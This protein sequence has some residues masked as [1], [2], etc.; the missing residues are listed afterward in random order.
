M[1]RL[2]GVTALTASIFAAGCH[3]RPRTWSQG[4]AELEASSGGARTAS[5]GDGDIVEFDLTRGAPESAA[6]GLLGAPSRQTYYR[7]VTLLKQLPSETTSR[8]VLIRLG[9]ARF[10]WSR[11]QELAALFAKVR[12]SKKQIVCHADGY[13]NASTWIIARGCDRIWVSPAGGVETTGIA[14]E[15]VYMN[16]LLTEKL[17]VDVDFLQIG[18]FKGAEEPFTRNGPSPEAK[19]SLEGVLGAI[20]EQWLAGITEARGKALAEAIE[21]GPFGAE[22][23]K[24]RGIVD[25]VG[26]LDEAREEAKKITGGQTFEVRFGSAAHSADRPDLSEVIRAIAGGGNGSRGGPAHV[27]LVRA[28]GAI[29]MDGSGGVLGQRSGITE[30][31]LGRTV[32]ALTDDASVKAVVLRI[33]SPGGSALASDLLWRALM[34]LRAKKPLVVSIGDM[35]ASGGYYLA[36]TANRIIAE[37]TSIVGS[38]GVV[39][40][41]LAFGPA[42]EQIGVHTEAIGAPGSKAAMR[43]SYE[44]L[45]LPWDA[46]TRERVKSE[47]T[48]VYDLFLRRVAEGR[49]IPVETVAGAAEGRIFAGPVAKELHLVDEWG[50]IDDA[51]RIARELAKLDE[52][53]PVRLTG[54]SGGILQWLDD[55]DGASDETRA[56]P[57]VAAAA[58]TAHASAAFEALDPHI[59]SAV[60]SFAPLAEGERTLAALPFVLLLH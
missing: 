30:R 36:C 54:E 20:R 14:A 40:G 23:A 28:V 42:L 32:R 11:A 17:G 43:A 13:G 4:R 41:K 37:P 45:L 27:A 48:A 15:M 29:S 55:D 24:R 5:K 12:E 51:I 34:Q 18:K 60:A 21:D 46:G 8:G 50:G 59:R 53:A 22:E 10:G 52:Q 57:L 2:L 25:A 16:R 9:S 56:P 35:A 7:L 3:G 39:G 44:S 58:K 38:I 19:A 33:D 31:A 47:M 6:Q 26:Y 1:K 49:G